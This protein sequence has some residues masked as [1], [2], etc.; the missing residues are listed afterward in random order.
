MNAFALSSPVGSST[1]QFPPIR[2]G[3]KAGRK[4][5]SFLEPSLRIKDYAESYTAKP[6][7][8]QGRTKRIKEQKRAENPWAKKPEVYIK[9]HPSSRGC[10]VFK[11]G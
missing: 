7:P 4:D 9:E 3:P 5:R 6:Q 8:C 10:S 1:A 2:F 11:S